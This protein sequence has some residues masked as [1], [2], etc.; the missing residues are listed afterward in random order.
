LGTT[1]DTGN[2]KIVSGI[3]NTELTSIVS[4]LSTCPDDAGGE[5]CGDN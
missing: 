3:A 4:Q 5:F 2:L 1:K